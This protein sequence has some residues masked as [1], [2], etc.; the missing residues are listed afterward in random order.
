MKLK[1]LLILFATLLWFDTALA[2]DV[3][4]PTDVVDSGVT[5]YAAEDKAESDNQSLNSGDITKASESS[6]EAT[7]KAL[8]QELTGLSENTT[9]IVDSEMK[10]EPDSETIPQIQVPQIG[11]NT[12][13]T[14]YLG[15][16]PAIDMYNHDYGY[17]ARVG[18]DFHLVY[19]GLG[20]EVAWNTLWG[21]TGRKSDFLQKAYRK[22]NTSFLVF[23]NGYIPVSDYVIFSLGGGIGLGRK[24]ETVFAEKKV[25]DEGISWQS[26]LQAG[27]IIRL[28]NDMTIGLNFAFDFANYIFAER[29]STLIN[30]ASD[31]AG[32]LLLSFGYLS[33][34]THDDM[35]S[36]EYK[37]LHPESHSSHY[38]D[39]D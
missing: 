19:F 28:D 12:G 16:G 33:V 29:K 4:I 27:I 34:A 8:N 32:G 37:M 10:Q 25:K 6:E 31:I 18:L 14:F 26:R 22:S 5:T 39:D 24:Y 11:W 38:D 3:E 13:F 30:P 36:D 1:K 23:M 7:T 9:D 17:A 35:D 15:V 20:L 21:T 2:Q